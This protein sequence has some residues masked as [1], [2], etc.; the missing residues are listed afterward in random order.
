MPTLHCTASYR[1]SMELMLVL[2]GFA[3]YVELFSAWRAQRCGVAT[4]WAL[5]GDSLVTV[6]ILRGMDLDVY[7]SLLAVYVWG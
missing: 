1:P 5:G 7:A 4:L 2:S 3:L 6:L